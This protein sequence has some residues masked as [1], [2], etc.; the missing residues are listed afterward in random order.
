MIST[1]K[2]ISLQNLLPACC[3]VLFL[4]FSLVTIHFFFYTTPGTEKAINHPTSF[5][6]I[7][8][9]PV[10]PVMSANNRTYYIL[11]TGAVIVAILLWLLLRTQ[12]ELRSTRKENAGILG[13]INA[14][15]AIISNE[16]RIVEMLQCPEN[17]LPNSPEE[18]VGK[19]AYDL[20]EKDLADL[21]ASV[22]DRCFA[23]KETV[24]WE[25]ALKIDGEEQ[26]F[27][28]RLV[29][30]SPTRAI[31]SAY[32]ITERKKA[33]ERLK[34][35]ASKVQEMN[36]VKDR[37]FSIIAHDL[38]SPVG[39]FKMLTGIMLKNYGTD[40]P[41]TTQ[42]MLSSIHLASSSLYD[43]LENLLSWSHNQ[44]KSLSLNLQ[45]HLLFDL[46]DDAID[47]QLVHSEIKNIE[48][49]NDLTS[50]CIAICDQ[51]VTLT[52][53]RNLI[54]NA[55][56]FTPRGGRIRIY[57]NHLLENKK[58]YCRVS[59]ADTGIGI[60]SDKIETIFNFNPNKSTIG[61][62]NESGSGLGLILCKE[63]I[64][65]QNGFIEIHSAE[66][67]GTTVSFSLPAKEED[68]QPPTV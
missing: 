65:K 47:S 57:C 52:V 1:L 5:N 39:S 12:Q 43:L 3:A 62:N 68:Q 35:S 20:F 54:S 44:R 25:Y 19:S 60:P 49:S 58:Q 2:P 67:E 55:I 33:E 15:I 34:D 11:I 28:G 46:V 27:Y 26:F 48:I 53:I 6:L 51:Y 64:E 61:T 16:K 22:T 10:D 40:D 29:Y 45:K 36:D 30:Q 21:M 42:Q 18:S 63:F 17:L 37:F 66:N 59:V 50:D 8:A 24:T 32:D 14:V 13:A 7:T 38:R 23:S 56:K 31:L 4:A 9:P 41:A